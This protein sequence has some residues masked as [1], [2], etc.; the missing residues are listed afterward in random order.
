MNFK[1]KLVIFDYDGLMVNSEY[2]V[3]DALRTFYKKHGHDLP[4]KYY[5]K[6]IGKPVREALKH[7]YKDYPIALSFDKFLEER[8]EIVSKYIEKKLTPMPNLKELLDYLAG[9]KIS[10]AI[11]TSGQKDYIRNGLKKFGISSYFK[12]IVT[13]DDVTRGK[14]YPDLIIETLK[15]TGFA[16]S[17]AVILED[18]P[19]GIESAKRAK[20]YSIAI[21]T[22]GVA[23]HKFKDANVIGSSLKDIKDLLDISAT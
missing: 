6:Y 17:E 15:R 20:I 18:S 4:W 13:V 5:C 23:L 2:V 11:A 9:E 7:F 12:T 10:M 22:R 8:N 16:P 1:L 14:P 19:H 21:P 3:Y